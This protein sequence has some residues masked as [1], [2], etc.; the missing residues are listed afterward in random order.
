VAR[1]QY[2]GLVDPITPKAEAQIAAFAWRPTYPDQL[3][4]PAM[5]PVFPQPVLALDLSSSQFVEFEFTYLVRLLVRRPVEFPQ[6]VLPLSAVAEQI[7]S[8]FAWRSTWPDQL[9]PAGRIVEFTQPAF[10]A[11]DIGQFTWRPSYPAQLLPAKRTAEFP[12]FALPLDVVAEQEISQLSW[13]GT[14]PDQILPARRVPEFPAN[15][16]SLDT[17]AEQ[18]ISQFV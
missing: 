18:G 5:L 11:A 9:L 14:W 6:P 13:R 12:A 3:L 4:R 17:A 10:V 1:W 15:V 7:I 2:L 16:W 8:Q